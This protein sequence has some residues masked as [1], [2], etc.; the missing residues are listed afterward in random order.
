M[1]SMNV[2]KME[3]DKK[4]GR[5]SN[6]VIKKSKKLIKKS[7]IYLEIR[8][9]IFC[10][11]NEK[12]F[13]IL[14]CSLN[15]NEIKS[16]IKNRNFKKNFKNG[17]KTAKTPMMV[18]N[19]IIQKLTTYSMNII[20]KYKGLVG[21]LYGFDISMMPTNQT[22]SFRLHSI[23]SL[24]P[25]KEILRAWIVSMN[26]QTAK[27]AL[28]WRFIEIY[29]KD[30]FEDILKD[31]PMK[32]LQKHQGKKLMMNDCEVEC[33]EEE[34]HFMVNNISE[35]ENDEIC[36]NQNHS[37]EIVNQKSTSSFSIFIYF[38]TW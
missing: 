27:E 12:Y 31:F 30:L 14:K 8:K 37:F 17:I 2:H 10:F 15:P 29:F 9:N 24:V 35:E 25:N 6:K 20:V 11:E 19:M 32:Q 26:K 33:V 23:N 38:K 13:K 5:S 18:V 21:N 36:V 28:G 1:E 3:M 7:K 4:E 22:G 34:A 16:A